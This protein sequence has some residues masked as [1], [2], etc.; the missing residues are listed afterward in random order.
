[1]DALFMIKK[2]RERAYYYI[3]WICNFKIH[4]P[5]SQTNIIEELLYDDNNIYKHVSKL[6][7]LYKEPQTIILFI[8]ISS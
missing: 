4:E 2:K 8:Q 5:E 6:T 7:L 3:T 1:M